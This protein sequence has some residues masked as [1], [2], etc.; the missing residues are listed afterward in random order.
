MTKYIS[1]LVQQTVNQLKVKNS[2]AL[3]KDKH[4]EKDLL[5]KS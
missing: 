4:K 3:V 2:K 1:N 5:R